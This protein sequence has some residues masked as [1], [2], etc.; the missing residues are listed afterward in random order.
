MT[1]ARLVRRISGSVNSGRASIV[2]L[3][4]EPDAD[5]GRHPP[6]AAGALVGRGLRDRLDGEALHLEAVA[7]AGDAG[8]AGVDDGADAGH[9]ERR[10]GD[11]GGQ[12]DP[13]TA[14]GGEHPVL[15]GRREPGVERQDLGVAQVRGRWSASAVSR[16]SRSPTGTRGCRRRCRAA[17][18]AP[19]RR[20]P[21][22][23]RGP[24]PRRRRRTSGRPAGARVGEFDVVRR[25]R[26]RRRRRR[27]RAARGR[28]RG[29][30][31]RP[32]PAR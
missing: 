4:V 32:S 20:W 31:R 17:A 1:D 8:G 5:A 23:G 13:A 30:T 22:S 18:R 21:R 27:G 24:A 7:V 28:R 12:H 2:V 15:L 29:R 6:A 26:A 25:R 10:L 14:V 9:G 3:A 11:V 19:R 16:I